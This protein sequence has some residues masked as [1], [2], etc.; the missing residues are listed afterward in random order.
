M[1]PPSVLSALLVMA[2]S[3]PSPRPYV[4]FSPCKAIASI[5]DYCRQASCDLASPCDI[6][7]ARS[8][9][10][11]RIQFQN[12]TKLTSGSVIAQELKPKQVG[13]ARRGR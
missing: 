10:Q 9:R 3:R 8:V 6:A 7:S 5:Y 1:E 4:V 11:V 13:V 2:L 12:T